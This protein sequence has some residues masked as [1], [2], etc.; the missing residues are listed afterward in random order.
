M[1]EDI[2]SVVIAVYN[3]E[4]YLRRC[5]DS[6]V[7][8][9]YRNL[10]IIC[11]D[12][13]SSDLSL[14]IL[15]SYQR[16]D[17]RI[18]IIEKQHEDNVGG[19]A[20]RNVGLAATT[21]EYLSILDS[22][23]YFDLDMFSQLVEQAVTND[24][25]IVAF[26]AYYF[27]NRTGILSEPNFVLNTDAIN[28]HAIINHKDI[29]EKFFQFALGA[30]WSM[31][32]RR[33]LIEK[34]NIAFQCIPHTDDMYFAFSTLMCAERIAV[35]DKRLLYYRDNNT[36]SQTGKISQ[37]PD[38]PY[39]SLMMIKARMGDMGLLGELGQSFV[40]YAIKYYIWYLHSMRTWENFKY[41]WNKLKCEY[42]DELMISGHESA[43]FYSDYY[44]EWYTRITSQE[45]G[46]WLF[47]EKISVNETGRMSMAHPFPADKI[48]N[49]TRV[50]LYGA[51][52]AGRALFAQN[53][54]EHYCNIVLW[55]DRQGEKLGF[56]I[57]SI[58][59]IKDVEFD[60]ILVALV[61]IRVVEDVTR[62][63]ATL[64]IDRSKII[65]L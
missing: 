41:L 6:V 51:G 58:D 46:E 4:K 26:N 3:S 28:A 23:D 1:S 8:Q 43:Y 48:A 27:D 53:A 21:G 19:G 9:T 20:A 63:L 35:C 10:E 56:P 44:Y 16:A 39:E 24:A 33:T 65:R 52:R 18:K 47:D 36:N 60:V 15:R 11:V 22:D 37:Y 12:D 59:S 50:V 5:L 40:N 2:V 14:E 62:H 57:H 54:V 29:S 45:P 64:S 32:Y 7:N 31:L 17:S 38:S 61:D 55:V 42:F 25:D 34:N 13:G 30:A 49:G